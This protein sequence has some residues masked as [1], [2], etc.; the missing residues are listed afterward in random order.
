VGKERELLNIT[1][2]KRAYL[3]TKSKENKMYKPKFKVG[4]KVQVP[5]IGGYFDGVIIEPAPFHQDINRET[6]F[7]SV[8]ITH[9]GIDKLS[10]LGC[11]RSQAEKGAIKRHNL[12]MGPNDTIIAMPENMMKVGIID[13]TYIYNNNGE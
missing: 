9:K 2:L 5:K 11:P 1:A 13:V 12:K 6:F 3:S 8:L 7:W 4:D 10:R